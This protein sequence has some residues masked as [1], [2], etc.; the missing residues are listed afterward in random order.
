MKPE[1]AILAITMVIVA[2]GAQDSPIPAS[3]PTPEPVAVPTSTVDLP[4]PGP[5]PTRIPIGVIEENRAGL[6]PRKK[7]PPPD[8]TPPEIVEMPDLD[9]TFEPNHPYN[10]SVVVYEFTVGLDGKASRIECLRESDF[11][12]LDIACL[13][14]IKGATFKPAKQYGN[15]IEVKFVITCRSHPIQEPVPNE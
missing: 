7:E 3:D 15:P 2:C 12:N 8:I 9:W 4:T 5:T 6:F 10:F 13:E 1:A 14:S 11:P